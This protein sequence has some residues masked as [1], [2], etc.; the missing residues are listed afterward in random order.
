MPITLNECIKC[1]FDG[2]VTVN[3]LAYKDHGDACIIFCALCRAKEWA[4]GNRTDGPF[5][6]GIANAAR[7]WNEKN[8]VEEMKGQLGLFETQGVEYANHV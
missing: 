5:I 4:Q 2:H 6:R 7:I 3:H 8:P 1:G